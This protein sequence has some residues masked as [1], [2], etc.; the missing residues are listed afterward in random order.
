MPL[1]QTGP[2]GTSAAQTGAKVWVMVG[3]ASWLYLW[4]GR[5]FGHA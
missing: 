4:L 2:A 3:Q 1:L 5:G